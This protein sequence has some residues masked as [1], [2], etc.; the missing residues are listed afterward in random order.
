M[1]N[2]ATHSTHNNDEQRILNQASVMIPIKLPAPL[3]P[4]STFCCPINPQLIREAR[5]H[6]AQLNN[7][8]DAARILLEISPPEIRVKRTLTLSGA[9]STIGSSV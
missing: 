4:Q 1:T 2:V 7:V 5:L 9:L 8:T 6:D 3:R